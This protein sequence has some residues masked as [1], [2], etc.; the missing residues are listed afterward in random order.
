MWMTIYFFHFSPPPTGVFFSPLTAC[1][2]RERKGRE[3]REKEM[4]DTDDDSVTGSGRIHGSGVEWKCLLSSEHWDLQNVF[5]LSE[6]KWYNLKWMTVF[7]SYYPSR[8]CKRLTLKTKT[9]SRTTRH[10]RRTEGNLNTKQFFFD[11]VVV[12]LKKKGFSDC[13]RSQHILYQI[14]FIT[15]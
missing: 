2:W 13:G 14:R 12:K 10:C 8:S 11:C 4:E 3:E 5:S 15:S 1:F 9:K 6:I 7:Y